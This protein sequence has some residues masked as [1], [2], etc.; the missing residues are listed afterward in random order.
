MY[1]NGNSSKNVTGASVVDGTLEN[2]DF[3]DNTISGDKIDAGVISNFQS[4]GILD[5]ATSSLDSQA[6]K[7]IQAAIDEAVSGRTAIV[8]AHRLS[9]IKHAD[10]IITMKDGQLA[11]EGT[12]DELL[13]KKGVFYGLWQEQKF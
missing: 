5:E 8:I 3:A 11:E 10:K 1:N 4:T 7:Q 9:T 6:E 2:A 13:E 12:L